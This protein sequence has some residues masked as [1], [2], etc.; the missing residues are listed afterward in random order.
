MGLLH[1]GQAMLNRS[2][3]TAGGVSVTYTRGATTVTI[4][5][6]DGAAWVGRTA[7]AST[8]QGAARVE[9]GDRD[10][11]ILASALAALGEPQVGDRVA[12]TVEGVE[13]VFEVKT[14]R[15]G[16]PAWRYSDPTRTVYR[17]HAKRVG[18]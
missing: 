3:G 9:W 1:R 15:T 14:P 10:Y 12:E 7:F 8:Q 4:L 17:V 16:E 11:L 18:T 5:D 13:L 2:L 6:T